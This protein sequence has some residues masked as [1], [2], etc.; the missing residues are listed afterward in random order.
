[1]LHRSQH[2][3]IPADTSLEAA[4]VQVQVLRRL[5][6]SARLDLVFAMSDGLRQTLEAGVRSRHPDYNERMTQLAAIRLRIG[7]KLFREAYGQ[8]I[9]P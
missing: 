5:S 8:D 2:L 9:Q 1:M 3:A 6:S 4:R 7:A